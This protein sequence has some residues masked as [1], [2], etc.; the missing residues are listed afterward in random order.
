MLKRLKGLKPVSKLIAFVC[1]FALIS[2]SAY[3][4]TSAYT[5]ISNRRNAV[6][7]SVSALVD[8]ETVIQDDFLGVGT[9]L[10]TDPT[11]TLEKTVMNMNE[12]YMQINYK[13][14]QAANP[15]YIRYAVLPQWMMFADDA[16]S[17]WESGQYNWDSKE[18]KAFFEYLKEFEKSG[19]EVLLNFGNFVTQEMSTWFGI[20]GATTEHMRLAPDN[21]EAWADAICALLKKCEETAPGVVT[22]FSFYNE[23][24][25]N[26]AGNFAVFANKGVYVASMLK[27]LNTKLKEQN[28]RD[29]IKIVGLD[30]TMQEENIS[31]VDKLCETVD[32]NTKRTGANNPL[33]DWDVFAQH[34]YLDN[35]EGHQLCDND[36]LDLLNKQFLEK[37]WNKDLMINEYSADFS[38]SVFN[39]ISFRNSEAGKILNLVN[40]GVSAMASWFYYGAK[41]PE[42]S[43]VYINGTEYNMWLS[44]ATPDGDA[45]YQQGALEKAGV[46][47]AIDAV[48][49]CFGERALFMNYIPNHTEVLKSTSESDGMRIA[50]FRKADDMTVIIELDEADKARD[51][52]VKFDKAINKAFNKYTYTYPDAD[53]W[54][55][56]LLYDAN[57]IVPISEGNVTVADKLTDTAS[58]KHCLLVYTTVAELKQ[59]ELNE[60]EVE[61]KVGDT[62][63]FDITNIYGTT[64]VRASNNTTAV[65]DDKVN[66]S[67]K[68]GGGS[69]DAAGSYTATDVNVGDTVAVKAELKDGSG[70]YAIAIVK[71]VA[72][73]GTEGGNS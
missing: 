23:I 72:D 38:G 51:I 43:D 54:T 61:L 4:A 12:A 64:D 16:Q 60:V 13:R 65:F 7:E 44:P 45:Y 73:T 29:K 30:L 5:A 24:G 47:R 69:V 19:T 3:A 21:L 71:I 35:V 66:W 31:L 55:Q 2:G 15:A 67:V 48:A 63:N 37:S 28:L 40:N 18:I 52:S 42:P 62:Y 33:G 53:K 36:S 26:G 10:W 17:K 25:G 39:T 11:A 14:N 41:V 68:V 58:S 46:T 59:I 20:E 27:I 32:Q 70:M 50:T 9:N 49:N 1:I 34:Y 8:T 56:C 57:A 6:N 22:Y